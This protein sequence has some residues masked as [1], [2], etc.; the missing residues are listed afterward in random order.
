MRQT[1]SG[2]PPP[3]NRHLGDSRKGLA[4]LVGEE[5]DVADDVDLGVPRQG[6]IGLDRHPPAAVEGHAEAAQQG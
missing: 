3:L 5:G 2:R 1:F 6:Q 4:P